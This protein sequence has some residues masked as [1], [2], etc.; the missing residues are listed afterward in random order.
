MLSDWERSHANTI[1]Y[2]HDMEGHAKKSDG[3]YCEL[4]NQTIPESDGS[5]TQADG[6]V[7]GDV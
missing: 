2:S 1:A 4:S 7:K 6:R 5:Q 3:K